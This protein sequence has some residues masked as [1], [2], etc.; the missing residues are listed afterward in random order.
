ME[1]AEERMSVLQAVALLVIAGDG[2]AGKLAIQLTA[3]HEARRCA[4]SFTVSGCLSWAAAVLR[5]SIALSV[6]E[7][8]SEMR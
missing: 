2:C 6:V 5:I 7:A 1:E 3:E 8:L 4:V